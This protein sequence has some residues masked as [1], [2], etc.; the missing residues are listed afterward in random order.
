MHVVDRRNRKKPGAA[1]EQVKSPGV[2]DI[3]NPMEVT[4][5]PTIDNT[6]EGDE[7][8]GDDMGWLSV[9]KGNRVGRIVSSPGEDAFG[10]Y[11][12][13]RIFG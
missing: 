13:E 5:G 9:K 3:N 8:P 1:I 12:M 11:L 2:L 7:V 10:A 6:G 4:G